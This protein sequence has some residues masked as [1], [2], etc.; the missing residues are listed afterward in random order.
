VKKGILQQIPNRKS[1]L[2]ENINMKIATIVGARPQFIKA[3]A[4]SRVISQQPTQTREILIH[5]G[6]HYD[7]NMSD[8]FF[9]EMDIARPDYH[10]GIGGCSQGAMTGRMIEAIENILIREKP[11]WTL[12]YGDTNSTLAG[13][14]ASVKL[15]IPVAHV[16]A[17]L[18]SF[19]RRMPEE[20]NRIVADQCSDLLFTPTE[21]ATKQLLHEGIPSN[22]IRQVGDVMY[23]AAL[24]YQKRAK[25]ESR[26]LEILN[27][28]PKQYALATI[29]RAEN[30]DDIY[31]LREIFF[32]LQAVANEDNIVIPLH[33]RTKHALEQQQ[34]FHYFN[35]HLR[36]ID[37]VGYLDM[38]Q[39][40]ANAKIILT[41]SGGVQKEAFFF[42]V[43]C[44]TLR[45]ETEW[46]ELL[47]YGFNKLV[48]AKREEILHHYRMGRQ[49]ICRWDVPLYGNGTAT[50][51]IVKI[52]S[53]PTCAPTSRFN[54][55]ELG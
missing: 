27:L 16:E 37:P 7:S 13:A 48:P 4:L 19:N 31:R 15:H 10:L 11:D 6:Q 32:G 25:V 9:K 23:D 30:T 20:I 28:K 22:K 12:I 41:D 21:A 50:H 46:R 17:G 39:L 47:E 24:H 36:L 18:R 14:L 43:P 3:A 34:L 44:L 45:E 8:V 54:T 55:A 26:I 33:P 38:M 29:H 35:A 49:S 1:A 53:N 5:T 51:E 52:L 2:S 40:E 42:Q